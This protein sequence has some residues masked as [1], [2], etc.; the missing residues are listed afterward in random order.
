M[1]PRKTS[2]KT[3]A[4]KGAV[5][6]L[7]RAEKPVRKKPAA[8]RSKKASKA[9]VPGAGAAAAEAA[10]SASIPVESYIIIDYPVSGEIV[11]G[12]HYAIRI[13][14]SCEGSVQIQFN[15]GEW[16]SCRPTAGYWWYDWG[17]FTPGDYKIAARLVNDDGKQLKKSAVTRVEVI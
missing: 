12:L 17:Y 6:T 9:A 3:E 1:P 15:G 14:A 11:S 8:T 4:T 2:K 7:V 16:L 13:G 5:D 10:G